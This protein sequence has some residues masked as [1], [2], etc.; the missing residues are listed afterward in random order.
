MIELVERR[1]PELEDLCR[2]YHVR[3]LELFGSAVDG[4]FDPARSDLDFL[5][6]FLP[7]A[8]GRVFHGYF[9]L[10]EALQQLFGR[11]VDLVM[12]G[13]IRNPYFLKAVNQQR[14]VLYAA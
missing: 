7:D 3:T 9:D 14:Q 8:A 11:E 13:A 12:P 10:K 5:V 1:R 4:T 2:R 6:E